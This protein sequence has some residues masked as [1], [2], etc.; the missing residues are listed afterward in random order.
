MRG[1]VGCARCAGH[2][3]YELLQLREI[4]IL[5]VTFASSNLSGANKS[6]H[7]YVANWISSRHNPSSEL[8]GRPIP[9][10]NTSVLFMSVYSCVHV[11]T[12]KLCINSLTRSAYGNHPRHV[13]LGT[14]NHK[15]GYIAVLSI[16]E[17]ASCNHGCDNKHPAD[18]DDHGR[19]VW[20]QQ[21]RCRTNHLINCRTNHLIKCILNSHERDLKMIPT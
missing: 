4:A 2:C 19:D 6:E 3:F 17:S 1:G 8:L 9:E 16:L 7:G 11:V 10:K 13:K 14:L 15:T 21:P 18:R 5:V 12:C 20:W